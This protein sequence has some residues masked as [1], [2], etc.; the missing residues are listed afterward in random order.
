MRNDTERNGTFMVLSC[1]GILL[2]V[3]GHLNFGVLEFG[4]IFPYYS[5]HVLIFVFIAGY[6]YKEDDE[7]NILGFIWRKTKRLLIP[8]Y[9]LNVVYGIIVTILHQFGFTFGEE[10]TWY[11]LLVEPI[12][13]GHQFELNAPAWFVPAL[14]LLEI[15]NVLARKV[16]RL[17]RLNNEYILMGLYMIVGI[18]AVWLAV[19][20]SVYGYYK[21][22]GRLMIMA[23]VLQFG[24]LY[25]TK[26]ERYDTLPGLYYFM[27]LFAA[28]SLMAYLCG[29]LGYS[30]VWATG[31]ANGPV[32]P[33]VTGLTGIALWLRIS[34]ILAKAIANNSFIR[35]MSKHTYSIMVHQLSAFWLVT[36]LLYGMGVPIDVSSWKA[37]IYYAYND[38]GVMWLYVAAGV[39]IPLG[40]SYVYEWLSGKCRLIKADK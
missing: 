12:M 5:Y 8:Y 39:M 32:I 16:L 37:D 4:G 15:I 38:I 9:I 33:F 3:L 29:G 36:L 21:L 20:G 25:R 18:G 35:Y 34:R 24:R 13:G 7:Q 31:F 40:L 26:L 30:V 11:N 6:F 17:I 28:N 22:P 27:I 2:V 10:I 1:I 23:P 14:F 19:R